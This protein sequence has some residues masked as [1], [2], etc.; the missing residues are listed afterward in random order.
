M[1]EE[2]KIDGDRTA[3]LIMD[4]QA[5]IVAMVGDDA[6]ALL[7][8]AGKALATARAAGIPVIYIA[9]GFRPGY[10]EV[11]PRNPSFSGLRASGR[12][13]PGSVGA[14]MHPAVAPQENDIVVVKHRVGAF[15][16]T[17][18]EMILRAHDIDTL[19]LFGIA[20]SGV[21]LSTIRHAA[22]HDYRLLVLKDCC[23]DAD[24][25]VHRVLVDKVFARQAT[26]TNA[27]AFIRACAS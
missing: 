17:D 21:V 11:S 9:V 4:Y 13:A 15:S 5:D 14:D 18:L 20:T 27:E 10:P 1:K 26:V 19:V 12:L 25:E 7:D 16:G 6:D 22:D 2:L 3:L 23:A 8:R 24:A